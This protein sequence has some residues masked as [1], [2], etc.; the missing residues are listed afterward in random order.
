MKCN[1][2]LGKWCKNKHGA[3]KIIDTLETYQAAGPPAGDGGISGRGGVDSGRGDAGSGRGSGTSR[4]GGAGSGRGRRGLWQG[5]RDLR[6]GRRGLRR[7]RRG[8]GASGPP[9]ELRRGPPAG[10]GAS[11]DTG[12]GGIFLFLFYFLSWKLEGPLRD[13][14]I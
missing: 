10:G 14:K 4:R 11:S 9:A 2:T 13:R 1:E 7:G 3:S 12:R 8:S 5:R 6:Q